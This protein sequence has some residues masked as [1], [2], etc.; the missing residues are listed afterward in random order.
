VRINRPGVLW[1]LGAVAAIAIGAFVVV[2][3]VAP[4]VEPAHLLRYHMGG[5]DRE[6]VVTVARGHCDKVTD[7]RAQEGAT[8]VVVTVLV[9]RPRGT[10]TANIV[11]DDIPIILANPLGGREVTNQEGAALPLSSG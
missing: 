11:F 9:E 10:C 7:V 5:N 2:N 1:L 8:S 3:L 6:I 4:R